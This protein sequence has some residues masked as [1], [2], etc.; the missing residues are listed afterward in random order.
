MF[1]GIMGIL[2]FIALLYN[3]AWHEGSRDP[4]RVKYGHMDKFM[5]KGFVAGLLALIPYVILT[6][7]FLITN[8]EK[9]TSTA[10]IIIGILYRFSNIQYI[11]FSDA[12]TNIPIVCYLLLFVLP[13]ASAVGYL[14]GYRNIVIISKILY[15][16]QK[17]PDG[18]YRKSINNLRK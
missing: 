6:T 15:K 18:T 5:L 16:N 12:F 13:A 10:G 7:A 1:L 2:I 17:R 9:A 3:T 4:N 14:A 8:S 11:V